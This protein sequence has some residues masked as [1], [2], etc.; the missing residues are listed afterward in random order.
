VIVTWSV[1]ARNELA[2]QRQYIAQS[3]PH[4]AARIAERILLAAARLASYPFYGRPALWDVH[5]QLRELPVAATP[6]V[7]LYTIDRTADVVVIVRVVQGAQLR[8]PE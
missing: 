8:G 1:R 3:Q 6:Y 7:V 5:G 4:A 2:D